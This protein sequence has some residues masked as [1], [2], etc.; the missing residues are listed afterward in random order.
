MK[1]ARWTSIARRK[2]RLVSKRTGSR[3]FPEELVRVF[4]VYQ[5]TEA[6]FDRSRPLPDFERILT[7]ADT[8]HAA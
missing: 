7:E 5:P 3:P 4:P 2:L 8:Q 6:Y 1:T